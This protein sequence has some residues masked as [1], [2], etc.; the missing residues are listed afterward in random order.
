MFPHC[1]ALARLGRVPRAGAGGCEQHH[2]S[3]LSHQL[4]SCLCS[5]MCLFSVQFVLK[6]GS[7]GFG[8][9]PVH[10][11][12]PQR[13]NQPALILCSG[14]C[15]LRGFWGFLFPGSFFF[16]FFNFSPTELELLTLPSLIFSKV[17]NKRK[18]KNKQ[19]LLRSTF[20]GCHENQR[21]P[22]DSRGD[23]WA[24]PMEQRHRG[25]SGG[26]TVLPTSPGPS[27]WDTAS[28]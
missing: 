7:L 8:G 18:K 1:P 13:R 27:F 15:Q 17:R 12:K 20:P 21:I 19:A 4:P 5:A 25:C 14:F 23:C 2:P 6:C 3:C 26:G 10:W 11:G 24:V 9:F 22:Q 16:F 28:L